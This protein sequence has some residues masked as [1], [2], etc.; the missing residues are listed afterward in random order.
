MITVL[1]KQKFVSIRIGFSADPDP[2]FYLNEDPDPG[3]KT[4]ANPDLD[5]GQTIKSHKVELSHENKIGRYLGTRKSVNGQTKF[6][7][8]LK[9][10]KRFIG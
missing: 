10:R 6:K 9:G 8:F 5:P 4:S 3:S 2:G 1:L 7:A